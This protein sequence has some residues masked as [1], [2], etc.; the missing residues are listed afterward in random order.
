MDAAAGQA[1]ITGQI[2]G[3]LSWLG[4]GRKLTRTGQIRLSDARHL[5]D[6]LSTGDR[7][8][9]IRSSAELPYLTRVAGWSRAARL[10][11]P[12]RDRLVP[13]DP[14]I[15]DRPL[16]LVLALLATYPE[17]G[18]TLFPPNGYRR[19]PVAG[20]FRDLGPAFLLTLL[21]SPGSCPVSALREASYR[22]IDAWYALEQLTADE[23]GNLKRTVGVDIVLAMSALHVLGVAVLDRNLAWDT[24]ELDSHGAPDW[25]RATVTLT[26]LG[27]YAIPRVHGMNP[28]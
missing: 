18:T 17:L 20:H 19:S 13:R 21:R 25:S 8:R 2:R 11:R 5:V 24:D 7:T 4:E 22:M 27:R 15:A 28:P 1:V 10:V 16:G 23:R 14:G 6:R 9:A 26:D 12:S 3:F